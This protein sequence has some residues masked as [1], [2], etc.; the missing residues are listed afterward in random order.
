MSTIT[1]F[2]ASL[3]QDFGGDTKKVAEI[4]NMAVIDM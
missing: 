2:S 3:L 4:G 1:G